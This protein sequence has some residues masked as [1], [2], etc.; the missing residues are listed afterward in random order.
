MEGTV[1]LVII[2]SIILTTVVENV[3]FFLFSGTM[4]LKMIG[5]NMWSEGSCVYEHTWAGTND[6]WKAEVQFLA[7]SKAC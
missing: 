1:L 6:E 4:A 3:F 2:L 7:K 5:R